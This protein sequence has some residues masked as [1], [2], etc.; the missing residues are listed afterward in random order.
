MGGE[1]VVGEPPGFAAEDERV[2]G[3]VLDMIIAPGAAGAVEKDTGGPDTAEERRPGGV[4]LDLHGVP[5]VEAGAAELGVGDLETEGF[6]EMQA[7]AGGGAEAGDVAG[8]GGDFGAD[9]DDV[10]GD[11]R[12]AEIEF[13]LARVGVL[14]GDSIGIPTGRGNECFDRAGRLA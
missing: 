10:E 8:V 3:A 12:P 11:L 9:E 1:Q 13:G 4:D 6:D 2:A 7:G 5:V 14:H